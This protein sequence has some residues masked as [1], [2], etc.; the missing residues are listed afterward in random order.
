MAG[1]DAIPNEFSENPATPVNAEYAVERPSGVTT[2]G[3]IAI[4]LGV[5]G[6]FGGLA[7]VF[8]P[9]AGKAIQQKIITAAEANPE[10]AELQMQADLQKK[11]MAIGDKYA[12][13]NMI[14]GAVMLIACIALLVAAIMALR[15]SPTGRSMLAA[16]CL[17]LLVCDLGKTILQV[18]QQREVM[19][20]MEGAMSG[21]LQADENLQGEQGEKA[22]E[23][24]GFVVKAG[25]IVGMVMAVG[26]FLL[27]AA[28]YFYASR[29]LN[30]PD[31]K[32][33]YDARATGV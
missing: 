24:I 18:I 7:G 6:G 16:M 20:G 17:L 11:T 5:L 23:M 15:G 8:G 13:M 32:S 1:H 14:I 26:W 28:F 29:Y 25:V 9:M 4:V 27:K 33:Y 22:Q 19:S 12:A 21:M 3:V 30:R 10:D 31:V 2:I